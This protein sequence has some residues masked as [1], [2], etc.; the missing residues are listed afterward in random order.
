MALKVPFGLHAGELVEP[1]AVPNGLACDCVCPGCGQALVAYNQGH[2][3]TTP[4]FGHA[5]GAECA[6]GVESALHLAGKQALLQAKRMN[7]PALEVSATGIAP[8]EHKPIRL[9]LVE[10]EDVALYK[11]VT[12]EVVI[13]WPV[14]Q[15][16]ADAQLDL[17]LRPAVQERTTRYFRSDLR[18]SRSDVVDW[19]E[20]RV[21]HAVDPN[22]KLAMQAAGLRV[23]EVDLRRLMYAG[24]TLDDVRRAVVDDAETK[25]WLA[26]PKVPAALEAL[27][28]DIARE[29]EQFTLQSFRQRQ[30]NVERRGKSRPGL[31]DE[32]FEERLHAPRP[33]TDSERLQILREQLGLPP[34]A[35]WPRFLD[36]DLAG[37]GGCEVI[38]RIWVSQLYLDWVHQRGG[39]RYFVSD[40]QASVSK[41][42]RIRPNWGHRDLRRALE[43]RVLPYW[44][45]CGLVRVVGETVVV[46]E[47]RFR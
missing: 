33:P 19:V 13:A 3:R 38:P 18:A 11:S 39:S 7:L 31:P 26:H 2:I 9:K 8:R 25:T 15:Q 42:F 46:L 6:G 44:Q 10:G 14:P 21:T 34:R 4:Y 23:I 29:S 24:V 27:R 35:A 17:F 43:K 37:N 28:Q 45:A 30:V 20:I 32:S 36:L 40:L 5:A 16:A 1:A 41:K 47:H 22:K 12:A